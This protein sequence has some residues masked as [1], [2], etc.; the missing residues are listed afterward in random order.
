MG[1]SPATREVWNA[2]TP[3]EADHRSRRRS[4]GL[5]G[6]LGGSTCVA[7]EAGRIVGSGFAGRTDS[8]ERSVR[9]RSRAA[10]VAPARNRVALYEVCRPHAVE[11]G[12]A[13]IS[14]RIAEHD[15]D[16]A[17]V[18]PNLGF[19]EVGRDVELVTR[20]PATR[21]RPPRS[22]RSRSGADG[23]RPRRDLRRRSRVLAGHAATPEPMP[24][25]ALT[26]VLGLRRARGGPS[27]GASTARA[28]GRLRGAGHAPARL[29]R[30]RARFHRGRS[31]A[32]AAEGSRLA[33]KR[34]QLAW[35]PST[36]IATRHLH[37]GG[38]SGCGRSRG[39]ATGSGLRGF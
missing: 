24:A 3:S 38:T 37:A 26:T 15:S 6:S 29:G 19:A 30:A 10:R 8:A 14:G 11:L 23:G 21:R 16:F 7:E 31:H 20:A 5:R 25:L 33:P 36:A 4:G 1:I 28:A 12:A 17:A 18:G 32:T 22:R 27:S 35:R 39:S 34:T 2:I 13:M 9:C